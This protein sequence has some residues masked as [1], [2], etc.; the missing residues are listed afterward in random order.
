PAARARG[1]YYESRRLANPLVSLA[2]R[3]HR[4]FLWLREPL[5]QN[6]LLDQFLEQARGLD[7]LIAN[8]DYS[9]NSA[10]VGVSDAAACQSARECLGKMREKF[11]NNF[12]ATF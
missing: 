4:R 8:G 12:R 9:C 1:R 10:F 11:G 6:H 3:L 2:G 5:Q 7:Y